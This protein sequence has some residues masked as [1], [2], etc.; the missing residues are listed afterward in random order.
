MPKSLLCPKLTKYRYRYCFKK[1]NESDLYVFRS[2]LKHYTVIYTNKATQEAEWHDFIN[3]Q[4][5]AYYIADLRDNGYL[6]QESVF[7]LL[8]NRKFKNIRELNG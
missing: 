8:L 7:P 4:D 1:K 2:N 5:T 6:V 3:G